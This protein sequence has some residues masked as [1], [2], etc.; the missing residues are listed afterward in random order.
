[1]KRSALNSFYNTPLAISSAKL[2]EIQVFLNAREEGLPSPSLF[3][4]AGE[5]TVIPPIRWSMAWPC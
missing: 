4:S 5:P 1:M 3:Q 2:A